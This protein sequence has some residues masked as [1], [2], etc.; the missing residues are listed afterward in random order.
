MAEILELPKLITRGE[1]NA[2]KMLRVIAKEKPR[3]V[4][5][6]AWPEDDGMPTYHSNVGDM[7]VVLM[8]IQEFAHKYYSGDFDCE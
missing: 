4:F 7:P 2:S 3:Y 1:L 6:I 5:V 8:R